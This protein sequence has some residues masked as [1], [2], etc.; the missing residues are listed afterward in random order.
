MSFTVKITDQTTKR[1]EQEWEVK[2]EETL[3]RFEKWKESSK[4]LN[5]LVNSS[6]STR[7]KIGLGFKEYFGEDEVFDLLG[8]M[9]CL[10]NPRDY[11]TVV[12]QAQDQRPK[13]PPA[14]DIRLCQSMLL[15]SQN[16][17]VEVLDFIV[18][19]LL[20][21]GLICASQISRKSA[22]SSIRLVDH[23]PNGKG[24]T[25][26]NIL[27]VCSNLITLVG[28]KDQHLFLLS[29][30]VLLGT[31]RYAV[32]TQ[33][34]DPS[35]DNDIGQGR[36]CQIL[37]GGSNCI[38]ELQPEQNV[39]C[40]VAKAS[41]DESTRWHRRMAHVNF[42]TINKLAKEGLVDGLPLKVFTNEHNCV[43]L[44]K[45]KQ[46]KASTKHIS[47]C[48]LLIPI[49][50]IPYE[51]KSGEGTQIM[52]Q[53]QKW[54][55]Q[56]IVVP[57]FT[58]NSFCRDP[59][60][61]IDSAGGVSAGSTFAGSDPAG[62]FQPAGSY[63]PAGKGNP[64]VSTSVS[65]C[66]NFMYLLFESYNSSLRQS[67]GAQA[68]KHSHHFL[69]LLMSP[70]VEVNPVP[71]IRVNKIHPQSQIIGDL[72]SPVLQ[73][74]ELK[75]PS[76]VEIG[77]NLYSKSYLTDP[78]LGCC[79]ARREQQFINQKRME[80]FVR[81]KARLVAQGHR[82]EEGIDYDEPKGFEDPY[83]PKPYCTKVVK[84]S[85][86]TSSS[87]SS[88]L[89]LVPD[90]S[91]PTDLS[92]ECSQA[93]CIR[94]HYRWI[95]NLLGRRRFKFIAV[96][97]D[98]LIVDT[99]HRSRIITDS[100]LARFISAGSNMFL[101]SQLRF[102]C[103]QFDIAGWFV[104]ATSHS[105]SAVKQFREL[106]VVL[107]QNAAEGQPIPLTT[108]MLAIAV[109]GDDAVGGD[110]AA[111]EDDAAANEAAGS[112]A[113]AHFVVPNPVS[114]VTDWRPWPYVPVHSPIRDPTPEPVSPPTPPAQ[115]FIFEVRVG[116]NGFK[117]LRE[118]RLVVDASAAEGDVD[119]QDD[120]DLDG[121][122]RMASTALGHDQPAVPSEDVEEREEEDALPREGKRSAFRRARQ[123]F[124]LQPLS[125][126]KLIFLLVLL[127]STQARL[128]CRKRFEEEQ[129]SERLVQRLRA[130][131]LA[132]EDLPNVSEER[133]K[134]FAIS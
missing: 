49:V 93:D 99:L 98:R 107:A 35:T 89:V 134:E 112:A 20:A 130:E 62:S 22:C 9:T 68:G 15:K 122:S 11:A 97:D 117:Q 88:L 118:T 13:T 7:T 115:T 59:L 21:G 32:K 71:T 25:A 78:G 38:S 92:S 26:C 1:K 31:R 102:C 74:A 128:Q 46:H 81:N 58:S 39:T 24:W 101:L 82:Q 47:V 119:I 10:Q 91:T 72:A 33:Q 103:T 69:V 41:L 8:P 64:A 111:S 17:N 27:P 75:N 36:H 106:A 110:D 18:M 84:A 77:T 123:S 2:Y 85:V 3:A 48:L 86:W 52:N 73:E 19:H 126:F 61:D 125:S 65:C 50:E 44:Q 100:R 90:S 16:S 5:K 70:A 63:E 12:I 51:L 127:F 37:D 56:V 57:S 104:S 67:F 60:V 54:M 109:A 133:A 76:L 40:L 96:Q 80:T 120:I 6:M 131:D 14:V 129:A 53:Y 105:V 55:K 95:V 28:L 23:N 108:P 83:F 29:R 116:E 34:G 43:C 4:N 113:E 87:T 30:P 132:Q 42:K 121:L 45:G 94:Y 114:P 79:Y 124:P 66:L